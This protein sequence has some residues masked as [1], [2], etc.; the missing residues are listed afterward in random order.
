[1]KLSAFA[2]LTRQSECLWQSGN[3]FVTAN[4]QQMME[5]S[6]HNKTPPCTT[7]TPSISHTSCACFVATT[8]IIKK[9]SLELLKNRMLIELHSFCI[10]NVFWQKKS[11]LQFC[12]SWSWTRVCKTELK[13]QPRERPS[14]AW[15]SHDKTSPQPRRKEPRCQHWPPNLHLHPTTTHPLFSIAY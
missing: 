15:L 10:L 1:M 14:C 12:L 7:A 13:G 2:F 9:K 3:A 4:V 8:I 5:A 11:I 6:L